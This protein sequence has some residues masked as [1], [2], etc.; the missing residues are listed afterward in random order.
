VSRIENRCSPFTQSRD[1]YRLFLGESAACRYVRR[2]AWGVP[3]IFPLVAFRA[4]KENFPKSCKR[5]GEP[6]RSRTSNLLIKS[7]LLCQLS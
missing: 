5:S 7:Q 4:E 6:R 2:H 3:L 1:Q